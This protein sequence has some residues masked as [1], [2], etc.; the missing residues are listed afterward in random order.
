[1]RY[2]IFL[3]LLLAAGSIEALTINGDQA[4]IKTVGAAENGQWV[5][6]SNGDWGEYL[7]FKKSGTYQFEVEARGS[8]AAGAWP[9]MEVVVDGDVV[10]TSEVKTPYLQVSTFPLALKAGLHGEYKLQPVLALHLRKALLC[11]LIPCRST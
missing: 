11:L 1:M 4:R 2:A 6:W 10:A 9:Q 7:S 8:P 5:L 3:Y